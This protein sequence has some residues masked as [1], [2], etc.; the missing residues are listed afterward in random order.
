M[1]KEISSFFALVF[2]QKYIQRWGLMRNALPESLAQHSSECAMITHALAV[3][4]NKLFG[5][6]YDTGKAVTLALYHDV[7]EVFTGDMPTP[8][9][10]ANPVIRSEFG[11]I[12]EQS[13]K[14]I[15]NKLPSELMEEYE[16]LFY[17]AEE[18]KELHRLVK[19]A[20]KICAFVKCIEEEKFHN[21][22]FSSARIGI[23]KKLREIDL[24]E[25]KYFMEHFLP[26]FM[27]TLDEQQ[28]FGSS[29]K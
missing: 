8:I 16:S 27:L 25:V 1:D 19:C 7:P 11:V 21:T 23:E 4:G 5:R 14:D 6:C 12:E 2:R 15:L 26:A 10:Y 24:S 13:A 3:I 28:G 20:D 18:D 9:K 29:E 22:E 17:E